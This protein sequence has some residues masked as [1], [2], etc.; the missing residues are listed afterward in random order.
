MTTPPKHRQFARYVSSRRAA[1][2]LS[3]RELA[4]RVGVTNPTI[5]YWESGNVLPQ[6]T[7][8]E[9]LAQALGVSYEDL[10]ALAGYT[11]PEGLPEPVIYTRTLFPGVSEKRLAEAKRLYEKIDEEEQPRGKRKRKGR[12]R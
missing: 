8:L 7:V 11:H 10:F 1:L 9:P 5:H 3:Q 2:G 4:E 12:R 6:A